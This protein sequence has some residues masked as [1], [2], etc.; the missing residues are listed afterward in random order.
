VNSKFLVYG[1]IDPRDGQL[2]YIGKSCSG[3]RRP[4]SHGWP[5]ALKTDSKTWK[6][7]WIA[8][9]QRAGLQYEILVLEEHLAA[10][11]LAEAEQFWIA[12]FRSLGC[13]LTNL[14]VG[15]EGTPGRRYDLAARL[16][17]SRQRRGRRTALKGRQFGPCPDVRRL[18]IAIAKGGR[19]FADEAGN[20]Y[21]SI[22]DAARR[23]N[24]DPGSLNKVL[25]GKLHTTGGHCFKYL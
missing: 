12:Y 9:L 15:G 2:R 23:L 16:E 11:P 24:L 18:K 7:R 13:R 21:R 19:P 8:D 3:L 1:L 14:T 5:S 25:H 4:V 6:G 10:E 17:M 20:T 22:S